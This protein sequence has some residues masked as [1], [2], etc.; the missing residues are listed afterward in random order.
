MFW[1]PA[2]HQR[3]ESFHIPAL[4][5]SRCITTVW[6]SPMDPKTYAVT[7]LGLETVCLYGF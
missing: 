3:I 7:T 2:A 6:Q 5:L 1:P 4:F